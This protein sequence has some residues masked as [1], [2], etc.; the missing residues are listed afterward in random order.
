[1][2]DFLDE[3]KREI[4]AR[5]K[6]L[7]PLVDEFHRLEAA[8]AALDGVGSAPGSAAPAPPGSRRGG[9]P[10]P[11]RIAPGGGTGRPLHRAAA[12]RA[13]ARQRDALQAG[14]R[15]GA[16]A[17][18]HHHPGDRR[19]HGDPAELPLP[20]PAGAA[21]GRARAQGRPR[22]AAPRGCLSRGLITLRT[23]YR[24]NEAQRPDGVALL[25]ELLHRRVD[26][27]LSEVPDLLAFHDLEAPAA[28]AQWERRHQPLRDAVLP[29]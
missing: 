29:A 14:P 23:A 2:A 22:L 6:E 25:L 17:P 21:E 26:P 3:K 24:L 15:A 16:H 18:G 8:A 5:L 10:G 28:E 12:A 20:R 27:G 4:E 9:A 19:G 13:P 1:M 11:P 7:R